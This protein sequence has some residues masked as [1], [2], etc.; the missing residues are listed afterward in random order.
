MKALLRRKHRII[1]IERSRQ[2]MNPNTWLCRILGLSSNAPL[3]HDRPYF[4]PASQGHNNTEKIF[5]L[6][7]IRT[8]M[9]QAHRKSTK[10]KAKSTSHRIAPRSALPE[11]GMFSA[12]LAPKWNS[13]TPPYLLLIKHILHLTKPKFLTYGL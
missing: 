3:S 2:A 7:L 11:G 12:F 10:N 6:K 13:A 5:E 9:Y 4:A 8:M 1:S